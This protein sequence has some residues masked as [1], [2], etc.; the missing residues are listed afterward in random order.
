ME[1]DNKLEERA[2]KAQARADKAKFKANLAKAKVVEQAEKEIGSATLAKL[3]EM[4]ADKARP[5]LKTLEGDL[6]ASTLKYL[7]SIGL[8]SKDEAQ[9][10]I[11]ANEDARIAQREARKAARAAKATKAPTG[12]Q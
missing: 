12:G 11:K 6:S 5:F 4:G 10:A 7:A 9:A 3:K 8:M 2:W 1:F